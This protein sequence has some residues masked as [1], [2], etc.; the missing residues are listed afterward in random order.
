VTHFPSARV[1]CLDERTLFFCILGYYHCIASGLQCICSAATLSDVRQLPPI[2]ERNGGG[3]RVGTTAGVA[4][5][6]WQQLRQGYDGGQSS[7]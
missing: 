7:G 3:N 5:A 1:A 4:T 6:T 2:A